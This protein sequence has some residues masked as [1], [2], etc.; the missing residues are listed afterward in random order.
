F[1]ILDFTETQSQSQVIQKG[2]QFKNIVTG[3]IIKVWIGLQ[4]DYDELFNN[5]NIFPDVLY[6]IQED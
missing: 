2:N 3:E 1:E 4:E 6:M 5:G